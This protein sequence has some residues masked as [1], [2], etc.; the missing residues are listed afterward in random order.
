MTAP[1]TAI[2]HL[3]PLFITAGILLAGN[4]LLGTLVTLRGAREGF[5]ATQIGLT[6]AAYFTGFLLACMVAPKLIAAVG[7]IRVFAA[8]AAL[9]A[10]ATLTLAM[11]IDPVAWMII[12][13]ITGFCFA[14]LFTV[15]ESWIND[16]LRNADRGKI[17]SLYRMIDLGA[18]TG[19]QFLLPVFGAD[20]FNIFSVIA[21][22]F[23][24]S[25]VPIT[26]LGRMRP[27]APVQFTF[28]LGAVWRLSPLACVGVTAIGLTNS[29]FRLM[30]P[31]YGTRIGLD[32]AGVATFMSAGIVGGAM[33]QFPLGALSDR[34]G[35]RIPVL[36]ATTGAAAAGV[37]LTLSTGAM[38]P[39]WIFA[40]AF[41]FGAC[42]MPLYSLSAA[43]ANDQA[44]PGQ[45][46][47]VAAGLMFFYSAGAIVGPFAAAQVIEFA[48]PAAFFTYTSIIHVGLIVLTL[49]RMAQRPIGI[50]PARRRFVALLRTSPVIFRL[51]RKPSSGS[52]ERGSE[53]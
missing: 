38:D 17:L 23:C 47:L 42:T 11:V 49:V 8:M 30:G 18:V 41:A 31:L 2:R 24:L 1:M 35:R 39:F 16:G 25:L 36:I 46:V 4:G 33:L 22:F 13:L 19:G 3:I 34:Y 14:G 44:A 37:F 12:R 6:G 10:S 5:S 52:S 53:K 27:R 28:D 26:L 45:F 29:A 48:G 40:G 32:V 20:G 51:A 9:S 43:H 21:I 15:V 7:H 50:G